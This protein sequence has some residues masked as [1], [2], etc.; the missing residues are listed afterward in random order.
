M[1]GQARHPPQSMH[2]LPPIC[3]LARDEPAKPNTA[4]RSV[5]AQPALLGGRDRGPPLQPDVCGPAR[6]PCLTGWLLP[7]R[8]V[9]SNSVRCRSVALTPPLSRHPSPTKWARGSANSLY[10]S[11]TSWERGRAQPGGEGQKSR[12]L[13][14]FNRQDRRPRGRS[15]QPVR[16]VGPS[17]RPY[18]P[19]GCGRKRSTA[20]LTCRRP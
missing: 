2:F 20:S 8:A 11:P 17:R 6:G 3:P 1:H 19:A 16:Q 15:R 13:V 7:T 5:P 10:P 14:D 9:L 4:R 12:A 18:P